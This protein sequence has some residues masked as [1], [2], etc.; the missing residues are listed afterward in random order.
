MRKPPLSPP[1]SDDERIHAVLFNAVCGL[2]S[3]LAANPNAE[4]EDALAHIR[5]CHR[6]LDERINPPESRRSR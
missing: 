2:E 6:V 1:I 3:Y 5:W 4:L